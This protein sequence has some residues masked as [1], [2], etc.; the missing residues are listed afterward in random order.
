M[1]WQHCNATT[2]GAVLACLL[3][4]VLVD[5]S[6]AAQEKPGVKHPNLLLNREEIEQVKIKIQ[7]HE[8]AARLL[9]RIKEMADAAHG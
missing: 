7:E 2:L 3:F 9:E 4:L 1:A 6:S 5:G 8:W